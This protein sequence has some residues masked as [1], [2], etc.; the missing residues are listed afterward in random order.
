LLNGFVKPRGK[1]G[2]KKKTGV[3]AFAL[4]A[5]PQKTVDGFFS[6]G[7]DGL[8]EDGE[9]KKR[10]GHLGGR[11]A[12]VGRPGGPDDYFSRSPYIESEGGRREK[13]HSG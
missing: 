7:Q 2:G 12:K 1:K 11:S 13:K 6:A 10:N 3:D 5:A 9:R 8:G 4:N